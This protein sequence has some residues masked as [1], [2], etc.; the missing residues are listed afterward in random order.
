[1]DILKSYIYSIEKFIIG[2]NKQSCSCNFWRL[3]GIPCK[4]VVVAIQ[5][6]F[7]KVVDYVN[8]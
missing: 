2:I 5:L 3:V 1:M 4:H 8:N 6:N 7:F